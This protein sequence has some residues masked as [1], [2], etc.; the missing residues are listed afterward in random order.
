MR[1]R[2][3]VAHSLVDDEVLDALAGGG[4]ELVREAGHV[5]MRRH[6]PQEEVLE[7]L[8][9]RVRP[10]LLV[11]DPVHY[12]K[13]LNALS[14]LLDR[15]GRADDARWCRKELKK[16]WQS[17]DPQRSP[18]TYSVS[19]TTEGGQEEPIEITDAQLTLSWF[20][21]DLVHADEEQLAAGA[22]FGVELRFAAAAVR[23]AQVAIMTRDTLNFILELHRDDVLTLSE[24]A[25]S[26]SVAVESQTLQMS[27]LFVGPTGAEPTPV[28]E[29]LGEPW[30]R[31]DGHD[32]DAPDQRVRVTIP[33]GNGSEWRPET[34]STAQ[35]QTDLE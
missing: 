12:G 21:G 13:V 3:V 4:F 31:I 30:Q 16:D 14:V 23:T 2:R 20:Y 22:R 5:S 7:S 9:A 10:L 27:G 35:S 24:E 19:I 28:G 15:R 1:A 8:A 17:V 25:T 26:T 18:M 6:L 11:Q 29:P 33:W 34:S 32:A